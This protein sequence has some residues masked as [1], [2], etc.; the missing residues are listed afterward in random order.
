MKNLLKVCALGLACAILPTLSNNTKEVKAEESTVIEAF[1]HYEFNDASN[2]GKDSSSHGFDLNKKSNS[3]NADALTIKT[4]GT[5]GYVSIIGDRYDSGVSKNTG[6]YL[7]APQIGETSKDFSDMIVGSFTVSFTFRADNSLAYGDAYALTFGRYG[8][9]LTIVPW[10]NKIEVQINNVSYAPGSTFDE[11]QQYNEKNRDYYDVSSLEWTN[12]TVTADDLTNEYVVYINGNEVKRTIMPKAKLTSDAD[13]DYT[14]CLGAQCN[15]YGSS[16]HMF[17]LCDIADLQIYD[18]VLSKANVD[19]ILAGKKPTVE[20]QGVDAVYVESI[21][22]FDA[23]SIDL[24]ITDVNT[25][26]D[27]LSGGLPEKIKAKTSDGIERSYPVFWYQAANNT[28]KG[29]VQTGKINP[30]LK[31]VVLTYKY[32]VKFTG[33]EGLVN[34][35]ELKI[36]GKDYTE[37][38][39][40]SSL[41]HLVS[42]KLEANE[43]VTINS[44]SNFDIE[45]EP[46]EDGTYYIEVAEGGLIVVD[47]KADKPSV[48]PSEEPSEVPSTPST[49][50]DKTS[51]TKPS[52]DKPTKKG[53]KGAATTSILG[54]L[55][56]AGAMI[57]SKKRK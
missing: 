50:D 17:G 12:V 47:A 10:G 36:D 1:A 26:S 30:S 4:D 3:P 37:G 7:Y 54:L 6:A 19:N 35:K 32:V 2:P 42:F 16:A 51:E 39:A 57:I 14:L 45:Y 56:I 13:D 5:E 34:V 31:E 49:S 53:C 11:R 43:G 52:E 24:D 23:S 25:I 15:I 27:I 18:C 20:D 48:E 28:I 33:T 38:D 55:A 9:C 46:E 40:I 44:V 22:E 8:S 29:Y 41:K 21:A